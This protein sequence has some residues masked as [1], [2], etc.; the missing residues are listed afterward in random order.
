[1][2]EKQGARNIP[3]TFWSMLIR[4]RRTVA[5]DFLAEHP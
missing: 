5:A 2:L 4:Q 3:H 1:M